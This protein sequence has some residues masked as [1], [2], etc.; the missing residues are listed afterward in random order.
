RICI[1]QSENIEYYLDLIEKTPNKF[2]KL[3]Y[4]EYIK[5]ELTKEL[6]YKALRIY[7]TGT[8]KR[9]VLQGIK[10]I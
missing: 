8:H 1:I 3:A 9:I 5:Q 2:L 10:K 4:F 6:Y 7:Q